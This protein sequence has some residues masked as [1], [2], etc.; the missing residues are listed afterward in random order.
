MIRRWIKRRRLEHSFAISNA[1]LVILVLGATMALVLSRVDT[2]LIRGLEARASSIAK[3]IGA[4][5]TPSLLAYNYAALQVAAEGAVGDPDLAYVVIHDKEGA[6]AGSAGL[7]ALPGA[8]LPALPAHAG[9]ALTRGLTV[10]DGKRHSVRVFEAIVPVRVEGVQVPWGTV[11]VGLRYDRVDAEL[12]R[13]KLGLSVLGLIL[14]LGGVLSSRLTARRIAAPLRKLAEGTEALSMGNI[15]HRIPVT[16]AV[17]LAELA[18][19]FNV[20]MDRVQEKAA[21]SKAYEDEL[22]ELNATLEQQV[23]ERT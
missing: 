17:E 9:R 6:V 15:E 21:E 18:Q 2:V 14:G 22:A 16:G 11:R 19:A 13:L 12:S 23:H 10:E 7:A 20:M 8:D 3:S 4:V 5:A 1:L